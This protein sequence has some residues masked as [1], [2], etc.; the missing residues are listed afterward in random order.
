MKRLVCLMLMG[1]LMAQDLPISK[2]QLPKP[3]N[4]FHII[5]PDDIGSGRINV[6]FHV[7]ESGEVIN[8]IV[9]DTFDISI[10]ETVIDAVKQLR[11]V[12]AYQNGH[13]VKVMYS[14]PI[15]VEGSWAKKLY[16][17]NLVY[18]YIQ[19]ISKDSINF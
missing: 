5:L 18:T 16:F 12:P 15:V 13:P 2:S 14:L 11:F 6:H 17:E 4:N 7:N 3:K 9:K 19:L 10:N 1:S 8:P